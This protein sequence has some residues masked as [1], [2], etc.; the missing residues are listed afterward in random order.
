M[1]PITRLNDFTFGNIDNCFYIRR[2]FEHLSLSKSRCH[3]KYLLLIN[4][5]LVKPTDKLSVRRR[6]VQCSEQ[7]M[8]DAKCWDNVR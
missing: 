1:I 6:R 5:N 4:I 8:I 7:E 3:F 2:K